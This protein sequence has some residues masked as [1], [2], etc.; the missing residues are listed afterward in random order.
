MKRIHKAYASNK[1]KELSIVI[2]DGASEMELFVDLDTYDQYTEEF[3]S[4]TI[5]EGDDQQREMTRE[6]L[7]KIKLTP[8]E[9]MSLSQWFECE[10]AESFE[11]DEFYYIES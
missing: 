1:T 4:G 10:L 8:E 3:E 5:A 11:N 6:D 9:C 7:D 2:D